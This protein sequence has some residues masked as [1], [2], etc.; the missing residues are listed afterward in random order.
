MAQP[1]Q[2][3]Q[4]PGQQPTQPAERRTRAAFRAWPR[5]VFVLIVALG[6]IGCST[7]EDQ[8]ATS[9][10]EATGDTALTVEGQQIETVPVFDDRLAPGWTLEDGWGVTVTE[11][12]GTVHNGQRAVLVLGQQNNGALFF[13]VTQAK[14]STARPFP[15]RDYVGLRFWIHPVDK[16]FTLNELALAVVGSSKLAYWSREDQSVPQQD[17]A[18]S[19]ETKLTFLNLSGALPANTWTKM[20]VWF[21]QLQSTPPSRY[22]TGFYMKGDA[23][24]QRLFYIDDVE[25]MAIADAAPPVPLQASTNSLDAITISFNKD[26][27]SNTA[28]DPHNYSISSPDDPAYQQPQTAS[29]ASYDPANLGVSLALPAVLQPNATYTVTIS[30]I[31]DVAVKPN[32]MPVAAQLSFTAQLFLVQVD[33][34]KDMHPISPWIYGMSGTPLEYMRAL[35]ITLN[36]WGGNPSTRYNWQLGNAWNAARDWQYRN[37]DYGYKGL[38]ASDDFISETL[39]VSAEVR[40]TLPTLG[41]VAKNND[42]NTC[43]FPTSDGQCGDAQGA[44]CQ[45][46]GEVADPNRANVPSDVNSIVRWVQ[47]MLVEMGFRVRFMAMDN[48]PDVWGETHYDVHPG[49]T[50]YE[51]LR[52]TYLEYA[53][54]VRQVAPQVELL[55]P[56]SCCWYYYWNSMGGTVDKLKH[57]NKDFL[58]WFLEEVRKNDEAAGVRTLDVL[59]VHYYPA[60]FYNDTVD[61]KTAAARLRST[62]SLWDKAYLDESWINEP[63]YLIPRMKQVIAENYPGTKFGI[64]EWNWGADKTMNG[65]LAI[66]DVLGI[67]GR[68]DV[69]FAS[70][71]RYPEIDQPGYY[72]FKMYTNYDDNGGRF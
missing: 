67:Y 59:D 53:A 29:T 41:W 11:Q 28:E 70:Y 40:L 39:S 17:V 42:N 47:H 18:Y 33:A 10:Q 3:S 48:E 55:G 2:P 31:A 16:P 52:D 9:T 21:N 60:G 26:L 51:E 57:G 65:A 62:R 54:A 38:S 15:R 37:G 20:E 50:T 64:S 56:V 6:V 5:A 4:Q 13:A 7:G 22:L 46:P 58:P 68:E 8:P 61:S 45:R 44:T 36:N 71:W 69:Y 49:C 1:S 23:L 35:S 30:N 25:L 43:S 72:A 66:A 27:D 24:A 14:T 12:G 32:V 34:A 19:G 63:V